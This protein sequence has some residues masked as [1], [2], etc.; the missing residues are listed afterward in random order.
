MST[1][2]QQKEKSEN[3]LVGKNLSKIIRGKTIVD[4][5]T[6]EVNSGEVIGLLGPNGAGKTTCF[7]MIIGLIRHDHGSVLLNS[8][9]DWRFAHARTCTPR[10]RLSAPGSLYFPPPFG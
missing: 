1:E 4:D 2:F 7:N 5:V 6:I 10:Y 3:T 9:L 8:D